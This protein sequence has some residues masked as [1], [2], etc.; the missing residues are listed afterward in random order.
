MTDN[1]AATSTSPR[2]WT[3]FPA[4]AQLDGA[5]ELFVL[6]DVH[7][8]YNALTKLLSSAHVISGGT[9]WSAGSAT[10]VVVGDLIDKG[11]DAP[12][13]LSLFIALRPQAEAAGGNV[14]VTMGNHEAEF[15]A[16]PTNSKA[17]SADGFDPELSA[18]GLTPASVAAG[19]GPIGTFL[20][21]LP[22]AA[23]VD[24][25]FFVHAGNTNGTALA[26]LETGFE[27]G[28]DQNGFASLTIDNSAVESKLTSNGPQWFDA[29]HDPNALLT[30]WTAALNATHLVMGHQ[31]S[32]FA[33]A[34]GKQRKDDEMMAAYNAHIFFIDTGLSVGADKTGGAI[35]HVKGVKTA[36][37]SWEEIH[38]DGSI[39]AVASHL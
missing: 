31:P 29:T 13:V 33:F 39:S 34:D 8:D 18:I 23:R 19:T 9:T 15:L 6:S 24:D 30:Q 27:T 17:E 7:G 5:S 4:I 2:D 21:D 1:G 38:P 37:V 26:A 12:D 28:I 16:D 11:P 20:H 32:G 22:I 35:L 3:Q 10:L 36:A 25:W 14:I